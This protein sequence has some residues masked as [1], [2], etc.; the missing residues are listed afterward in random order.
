MLAGAGRL[1]GG[2]PDCP[3]RRWSSHE[4]STRDP[5][6][7][8]ATRTVAIAPAAAMAAVPLPVK[9]ATT[10]NRAAIAMVVIITRMPVLTSGSTG[11]AFTRT[12]EGRPAGARHGREVSNDRGQLRAS[13]RGERLAR[14]H[15]QLVNGQPALGERALED[16]DRLL[17]VGV[18]R[19]EFTTA[20]A[21]F[22][23]SPIA[24]PCYHGASPTSVMRRSVTPV[25]FSWVSR[26]Q[27]DRTPGG[28]GVV[29]PPGWGGPPERAIGKLIHLP[30]RVLLEPVVVTTL[31]RVFF[32]TTHQAPLSRTWQSPA[33][34]KHLTKANRFRSSRNGRQ[35]KI[36]VTKP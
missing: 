11:L 34:S 21:F 26:R 14:P 7:D 32:F 15:I 28:F 33:R 10:S 1:R 6:R 27:L 4:P 13:P 18:R 25:T 24:R 12:A 23:C 8:A 30:P 20:P 31:G 9:T 35:G 19:A 22:R 29:G 5:V 3:P 2:D 17:A 36:S 16:L